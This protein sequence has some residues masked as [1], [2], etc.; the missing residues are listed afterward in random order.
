MGRGPY[1]SESQIGQVVV[2][3]CSVQMIAFIFTYYS[4]GTIKQ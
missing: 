2:L 1:A 4:N 3:I